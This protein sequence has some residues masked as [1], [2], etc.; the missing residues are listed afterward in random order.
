MG[1]CQVLVCTDSGLGAAK[2]SGAGPRPVGGTWDPGVR[3]AGR[4]REDRP[5]RIGGTVA[6][7]RLEAWGRRLRLWGTDRSGGRKRGVTVKSGGWTGRPRPWLPLAFQ[8]SLCTNTDSKMSGGESGHL[9][10]SLK[11]D[12]K[13]YG[14]RRTVGVHGGRAACADV[15]RAARC[16]LRSRLE[17]PGCG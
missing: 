3:S 12:K 2:S 16:G 14:V 7:H 15:L 11:L 13:P 17:E 1:V 8:C 10:R 6:R 9:Q 4:E 5:V